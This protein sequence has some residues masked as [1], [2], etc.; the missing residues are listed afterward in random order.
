MLQYLLKD[1]NHILGQLERKKC[2]TVTHHRLLFSH[3]NSLVQQK[4]LYKD[5]FQSLNGVAKVSFKFFHV[6]LYL[7]YE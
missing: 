3:T 1:S 7:T 5:K 2:Y 6:N 4:L